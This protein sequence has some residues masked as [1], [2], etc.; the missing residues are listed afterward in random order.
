MRAAKKNALHSCIGHLERFA[1]CGL[2]RYWPG[3]FESS[4]A[5]LP[6]N[7]PRSA[8][9]LKR[10]FS[11]ALLQASPPAQHRFF[12]RASPRFTPRRPLPIYLALTTTLKRYSR[13]L[14]MTS[15]SNHTFI[16]LFPSGFL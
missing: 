5:P 10:T 16:S 6:S 9:E 8:V 12:F 3:R 14:Y 13:L 2:F 4:L 11:L 15:P 7:P 1:G